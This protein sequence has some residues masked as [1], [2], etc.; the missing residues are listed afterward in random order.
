MK[1][2]D[3]T[4]WPAVEDVEAA[5]VAMKSALASGKSE[6]I[7]KVWKEFL[8]RV[9]HKRLGRILIGKPAERKE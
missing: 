1:L 9:G 5:S 4:E 8:N 3:G 2:K 6:E 7:V